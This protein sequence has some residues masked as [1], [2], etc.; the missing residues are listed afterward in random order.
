MTCFIDPTTHMDLSF[1]P[2]A[3]DQTKAYE[4]SN[5]AEKG[6]IFQNKDS[7]SK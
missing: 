2:D 1:I 6:D 5:K 3:I 7:L 4:G